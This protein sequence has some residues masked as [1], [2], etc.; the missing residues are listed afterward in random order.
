M[1]KID[2]ENDLKNEIQVRRL[3]LWGEPMANGA[4]TPLID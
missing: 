3:T 4:K 2:F 1:G